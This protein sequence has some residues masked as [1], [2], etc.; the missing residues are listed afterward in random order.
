MKNF[1]KLALVVVLTIAAGLIA[2]SQTQSNTEPQEPERIVVERS[3]VILDAVVR[4]KKGRPVTN[5]TVADFAVY[6][7]GVRQQI[8]SF[9]LVTKGERN[10]AGIKPER[11]PAN[12][13]V[14]TKTQGVAASPASGFKN[15]VAV[16]DNKP[17]AAALVFD[18]L[19]LQMRAPERMRRLSRTSRRDS[20]PM[21]T[22]VSL[23][24]IRL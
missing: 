14:E 8:S 11:S 7:D 22:L 13:K 2:F 20:H 17:G 15:S 24:S 16:N 18:R 23:P 4:D 10:S 5:L 21:T 19:S 1:T 9:R 12:E 6:E 3:E